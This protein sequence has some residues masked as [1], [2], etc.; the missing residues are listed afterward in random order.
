MLNVA[1]RLFTTFVTGFAVKVILK[2]KNTMRNKDRFTDYEQNRE[3][4][5]L[6]Q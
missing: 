6:K 2:G 5:I 3:P 4:S 1:L